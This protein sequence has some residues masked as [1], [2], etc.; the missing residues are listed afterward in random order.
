V[1]I[2]DIRTDSWNWN[3]R[4]NR[5]LIRSSDT[6]QLQQL[7][8]LLNGVS[9]RTCKKDLRQWAAESTVQHTV[10]SYSKLLDKVEYPS[11]FT[12]TKLLWKGFAPS[13]IKMFLWLFT[14]TSDYIVQGFFLYVG[15]CL[16]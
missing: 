8:V 2:G 15:D 4:W 11:T 12:F 14:P 6:S 16:I 13:K 9:L 7:I 5:R 1:E 10:N 3:F